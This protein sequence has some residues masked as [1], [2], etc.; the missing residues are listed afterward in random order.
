MGI[1]KNGPKCRLAYLRRTITGTSV[2]LE[3]LDD[4]LVLLLAVIS[5]A[6]QIV[7]YALLI[8]TTLS[9]ALPIILSMAMAQF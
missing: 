8:W 6:F 9:G 3:E 4:F 5:H 1:G 7:L 2:L